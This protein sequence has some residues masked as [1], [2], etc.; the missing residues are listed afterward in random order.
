[1]TLRYHSGD[2]LWASPL[3]PATETTPARISAGLSGPVIRL[4]R[5][6]EIISSSWR[7][8]TGAA[9][10]PARKLANIPALADT[11]L[12]EQG[13]VRTSDWSAYN[14]TIGVFKNPPR[15]ARR[16]PNR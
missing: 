3:T 16:R 8:Q 14:P 6:S 1:M 12:A 5:S 11:W 15:A 10:L 13:Y 4:P 2:A 9:R 7:M